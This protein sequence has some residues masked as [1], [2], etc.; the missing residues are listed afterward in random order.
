MQVSQYGRDMAPMVV[1]ATVIKDMNVILKD[2][3][4]ASE[5]QARQLHAIRRCF[6]LPV[7]QAYSIS[8]A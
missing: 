7:T 2:E 8:V 5:S 3:H 4:G 6:V 1:V